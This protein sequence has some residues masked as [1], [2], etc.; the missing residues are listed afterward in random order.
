MDSYRVKLNNPKTIL[1][2]LKYCLQEFET[3]R[4]KHFHTLKAKEKDKKGAIDEAINLLSGDKPNYLFFKSISQKYL[5]QSLRTIDEFNY[6]KVIFSIEIL[7][8]ENDQYLE[9]VIAE[10]DLLVTANNSTIIS[11]EKLDY[12]LNILFSELI[13][14]GFSKGFLFKLVYGTFVMSLGEGSNFNDHFQNFKT[15]ISDSNVE[16]TVI[17]RVDTTHKVY[18]A[19]STISISNPKLSLSDNINN[20]RLK[21]MRQR[22]ELPSFNAP[23]NA[24]K[25]IHCQVTATDYLSALKRARSVLSEYL[26]VIN[27]GLSDESLQIYHRAL[28]IDSRSPQNGNFQ[29]NVHILD[30][31]YRVT[32]DHY[33]EFTKKLPAILNDHLIINETKEKIKSAIRYLRLGN[34]STEVEHKF[35]NYWIG[36]EYLFS[37]YESQH[38]INRIKEHFINA[39]CLAYVKRNVHNLKNDIIQL[40]TTDQTLVPTYNVFDDSFLK[41]ESFYKEVF[42]NLLSKFPLLA[43]RGM[44]LKQ[45]FFKN[46]KT[47][48]AKD[49]IKA[50]KEHLEIHFTRIYRL[51]NEIIHD[52]ATNTNNEQITSNLR[53]YLTFIL[54]ELI[55]F[56]S[57]PTTDRK[58]IEEYFILNE[59][60]LGN[61]E[62]NGYLLADLL[63]V[64]CSLGF[65]S[66]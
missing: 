66:S 54:N 48:N 46:G 4:I 3:G 42:T 37:N 27:L 7:L 52:A 6:R 36:L 28:V 8:S 33:L 30:G 60:K 65:I 45:W 22:E 35:I 29:H 62:Q 16:H 41:E 61:I 24:R 13:S 26:D 21:G 1:K 40:S 23:G 56:L 38:T 17:F 57:K 19:I 10:L 14:N 64:D 9:T 31:K 49:Y 39:H 51:R 47:G 50:H 58:S 53:Y 34:Q 59:I 12:T 15:R 11:L 63:N 2:E 20:I 43:Y 25:F 5:E 55:D 18:D 32:K 44:K